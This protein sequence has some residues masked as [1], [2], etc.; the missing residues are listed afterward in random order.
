MPSIPKVASNEV[1]ARATNSQNVLNTL[2]NS[3]KGTQ[4]EGLLPHLDADSTIADLRRFG[5]AAMKYTPIIN[6]LLGMVEKIAQTIVVKKAYE[7]PYRRFKRGILELGETVEEVFMDMSVPHEFDQEIAEKEVEK[8]EFNNLHVAYHHI[9]YKKY[10]KATVSRTDIESVFLSWSGVEDLISN[11][12]TQMYSGLEYS[13]F[14]ATLYMLASDMLNGD[15]FPQQIQT[16]SAENLKSITAQIQGTALGWNFMSTN[17]NPAGVR[18]YTDTTKMVIFM[19]PEFQAN[20]GVE[21]LATAFNVEYTKF[22]AMTVLVPGFGK[23][24]WDWLDYLFAEQPEYRRFTDTEIALLNTVPCAVV[25]VDYFMIFERLREFWVRENQ[26]GLYTNNFLHHWQMFST[27][28][29]ANRM[30]FIPGA[31]SVT[32]VTVSP[33]TAS[34]SAGA[35]LM[36]SANVATAN[37][38]NKSVTWASNNDHVIVDDGG[39]V[40]VMQGAT[41]TATITA[42]STADTTKS[43]TATITIVGATA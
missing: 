38:A 11:I 27:S 12:V 6:N 10:F 29:F 4:Y 15:F 37:L 36:L 2:A 17:F 23:L 5:Q 8:R 25:D 26:Q 39:M 31:P 33:A 13:E 3:L 20:M 34:L 9:N 7:N 18:T 14:Q 43:G 16:V 32:G 28:P 24:D 22:P 40:T 35:S 30:L 21:V 41:G 1:I 42:T 19:T